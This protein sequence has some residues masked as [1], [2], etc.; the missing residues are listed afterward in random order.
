MHDLGN[1]A[2]GIN[3]IDRCLRRRRNGNGNRNGHDCG[4][5]GHRGNVDQHGDSGNVCTVS[6]FDKPRDAANPW[7]V[8]SLH[9]GNN[10][11]DRTVRVVRI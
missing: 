2:I 7:N 3:W 6:N 1:F 4:N 9:N 11:N 10:G 8:D 5:S